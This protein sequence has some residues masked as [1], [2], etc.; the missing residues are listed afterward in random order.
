MNDKGELTFEITAIFA[1]ASKILNQIPKSCARSAI[2]RLVS[3]SNLLESI[4]ISKIL[5]ANAKNGANGKAA[6]KIVMKPNWIT[7]LKPRLYFR[8]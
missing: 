4:R 2:G 6:T 8:E 7:K 1:T 3:H 5:L